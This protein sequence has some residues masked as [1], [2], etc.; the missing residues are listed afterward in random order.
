MTMFCMSAASSGRHYSLVGSRRKRLPN[1]ERTESKMNKI[2]IIGKAILVPDWRSVCSGTTVDAHI[3]FPLP[4]LLIKYT[5][6]DVTKPTNLH[7]RSADLPRPLPHSP[8][9]DA[10]YC[11]CLPC[12][13]ALG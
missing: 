7:A 8:P 9:R 3:V 12:Y 4:S 11:P 1:R 5:E 10:Q 13:L 6:I 2:L